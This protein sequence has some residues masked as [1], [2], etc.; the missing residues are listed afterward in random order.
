MR[1]ALYARYSSENQRES[2]IDD[3]FRQA[4]VHAAALGAVVVARHA[5]QSVSGSIP[6]A[7]RPGA[8]ALIASTGYDVLIVESLDRLGRDMG[9]L[10]RT[11]RRLEHRG[12]RIVGYADGY[13]SQHASRKVT[14]TVRGLVGELYLDDLREKTH[15]GLAGQVARGGSAGGLPYG[16]RTVQAGAVR[17]LEVVPERAAI[18]Q[19][20]FTE[21]DAGASTREIAHRLNAEHVPGPRGTWS[22]TALCGGPTRG[23]G[24]LRNSVYVGRYTWNRSRWVKDPDTGRRARRERPPSEWQTDARPDLAIIDAA[25]WQRVQD[26]L[27]LPTRL[28]G[29]RGR[30]RAPRTLLSGLM[31]CGVCGGAYVAVNSHAYGCATRKDRGPAVCD[32]ARTASRARFHAAVLDVLRADLLSPAA[33]ADVQRQAR[34]ELRA[35]RQNTGQDAHAREIAARLAEIDR[36]ADAIGRMGGSAALLDRLRRAEQALADLRAQPV[37]ARPV[38]DI[39]PDIAGRWRRLIDRLPQI[40]TEHPAEARTALHGLIGE[41]VMMP[42]PDGLWAE[43]D[44]SYAALTGRALSLGMVAGTRYLTWRRVLRVA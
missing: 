21:Y 40:L 20:I 41:I 12:V 43:I 5:D 14:R 28:G 3:Q 42:R 26:R 18:V 22:H 36:L 29:H 38:P 7:L 34:A 37:T 15:R 24:I 9:D 39:L 44:G 11:V 4:D 31:R 2:S 35:R 25:L 16:Y 8:G 13:D 1:A 10:E 32:N 30:G 6:A 23:L 33:L 19:R 27:A 17:Q